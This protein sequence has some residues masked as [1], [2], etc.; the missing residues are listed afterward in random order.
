MIDVSVIIVN[1]NAHYF[2]QQ[3]ITSVLASKN[4]K[5]EIIVVDNNS[6]DKSPTEIAKNFP[7][8]HLIKNKTNVGFGKANNQAAK[9]AKGKYLLI[10]NPDTVIAEDCL[11]QLIH[12]YKRKNNL[13][14]TGVKLI[15][16]GGFFAPESKRGFPSP[17]VSFNKLFGISSKTTGKYYATHIKENES[18]VVDIL[19]GSFMFLKKAV[20]DEVDGFDERFFMYGEDI[21]LSYRVKINGYQNY[22][23]SKSTAIHYKG[24]STPKTNTYLKYF[25]SAMEIFYNKHF[26]LNAVYDFIMQFGIKFWYYL[27]YFN[28]LLKNNNSNKETI[29]YLN[30]NEISNEFV[31]KN[32][33]YYLLKEYPI[34]TIQF[35][36]S[37]KQKNVDVLLLDN[38]YLTFKEI[39]TLFEAFKNEGVLF[40]IRP[41][42][43]NY[44]IGSTNKDGNGSVLLLK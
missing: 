29:Q 40:K 28:L 43:S 19:S 35:R 39:I 42:H 6:E 14:I 38:N 31:F 20:F 9:L 17:K 7:Q 33:T 22:Y 34:N 13:G 15:D 30:F 16:G 24:E 26:K 23:L 10:L 41:K 5:V 44:I 21:D 8:V 4:V 25:H 18:G 12:L 1:F 27:K 37:L 32:H 36:N 2:I 11:E 3:C